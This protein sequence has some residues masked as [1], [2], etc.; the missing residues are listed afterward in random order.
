MFF[1]SH[2]L[3]FIVLGLTY[4]PRFPQ[5]YH[6]A[7]DHN[8]KH[9]IIAFS[10]PVAKTEM[11][12]GVVWGFRWGGV[13]GK[14]GNVGEGGVGE[15][16][17]AMLYLQL[18]FVAAAS[19][20]VQYTRYGS[21]HTIWGLWKAPYTPTLVL[22]A[23]K[24]ANTSADGLTTLVC[25]HKG[26]CLGCTEIYKSCSLNSLKGVLW[27]IKGDSRSIEHILHNMMVLLGLG[28]LP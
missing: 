2:I 15:F 19:G 8:P 6:S 14:G 13:G 12:C 22:S 24:I 18:P 23:A 20:Y 7:Y 16:V 26:G 25:S 17:A 9:S 11:R 27:V 4:G 21:F 28:I 1:G 3:A 10:N 5:L